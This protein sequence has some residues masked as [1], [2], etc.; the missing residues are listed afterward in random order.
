VGAVYHPLV[1]QADRQVT[2]LEVLAEAG[3]IQ[4]DAGDTVIVTRRAAVPPTDS[5]EP[6]AIGPEDPIPA[7]ADSKE[8][9]PLSGPGARTLRAIPSLLI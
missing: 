1:Y 2:V 3:G 5:S 9:P 7:A 4:N 8:P 6:P